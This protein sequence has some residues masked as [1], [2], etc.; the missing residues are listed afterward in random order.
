MRHFVRNW[1]LVSHLAAIGT[2][3]GPGQATAQSHDVT[4]LR[5]SADRSSAGT[6]I[7]LPSPQG[8]HG[9]GTITYHWV[10]EDLE[11]LT[12]SPTD[13]KELIVQLF[14]PAQRQ[15]NDEDIAPYIPELPLL[16]RGLLT[17]GF[18]PFREL[19]G[20]LAAYG[21][22]QTVA[23]HNAQLLVRDA[24]FP[25]VLFSPGGNMSR[26][27]HT[28]LSQELASHGYVVAVMSH[29]HSGLDVFPGGGFL[30]SHLY[31]H[32]GKEVP[33]AETERRDRELAERLARDAEAVV[34]WLERLSDSGSTE[35]GSRLDP[36]RVGIIGHSRGGSTVTASCGAD[37][38][39]DVCIT[40]DNLG[41][42][43]GMETALRQPR[44]TVRAPWPDSRSQRLDAILARSS[45]DA[46][47]VV[48]PGASHYSFT[49]L[50]MV[51]QAGYPSEGI[52]P[53]VA[54]EVVSQVTLA[55][56]E[57]YLRG[58]EGAFLDAIADLAN[59]IEVRAY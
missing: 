15:G 56:L 52:D 51:D 10:M 28:A 23:G 27:W 47:D 31:W 44:M 33:A 22:V 12:A 37:D 20:R 26:H 49:D 41:D 48:I 6:M 32:P 25:V 3:T 13:R 19:S 53:E 9:V 42:V 46:F 7:G 18:P 8:P 1:I 24:P 59:M 50:P 29:S 35:L 45:A 58:Q 30:A 2:V 14:Y 4:E 57:T 43:S 34:D 17:H 39:I 21:R 54:H 11:D 38:R 16:R 5:F 40:F 55:F 36:E